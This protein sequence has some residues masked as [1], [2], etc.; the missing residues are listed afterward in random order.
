MYGV[1]LANELHN[2][3]SEQLIVKNQLVLSK[4]EVIAKIIEHKLELKKKI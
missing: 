3:K 4:E 1:I 2:R